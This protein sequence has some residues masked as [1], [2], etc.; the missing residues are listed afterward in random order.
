MALINKEKGSKG[1]RKTLDRYNEPVL[2]YTTSEQQRQLFITSERDDKMTTLS[3]LLTAEQQQSIISQI[4]NCEAPW[5]KPW[6]FNQEVAPVN[7]T[8]GKTY[9]GLNILSLIIETMEKGHT[10]YGWMTFK[11]AKEKGYKIKKGSKASTVGYY[12]SYDKKVIDKKTGEESEETRMFF[13]TFKVFNV[14]QIEDKDGN[15]IDLCPLVESQQEWDNIEHAETVAQ[16]THI[17]ISHNAG[18]RAFYRRDTDSVHLPPRTAFSDAKGYYSTLFHELTHATG[19]PHRL[20][21][22]KGSQFGDKKYAQEE[23]VAEIGAWLMAMRLGLPFE[24]QHS[25]S[26]LKGW[27]QQTGKDQLESLNVAFVEAEKAV[28]WIETQYAATN[29][30]QAA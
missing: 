30:K 2:R 7:A 8:T 21:R 22:E 9:K 4:I 26:Y 11:Q 5:Q 20:N 14:S 23:L 18:D 29:Q 25:A 6:A 16:S 13:K 3:K 10:S 12:N 1:K 28:N 27:S 15:P 19:A 24:P 17:S